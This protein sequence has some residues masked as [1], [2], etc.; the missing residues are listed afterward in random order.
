MAAGL[1]LRLLVGLA[2]VA[3]LVIQPTAPEAKPISSL[4][5]A[6]FTAISAGPDG[7]IVW[8][9]RIP[10]PAMPRL[11][12]ESIVYLP[13]RVSA[14]VRYPVVYLLQGFYGGPLQFVSG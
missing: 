10:D 12:R 11:R 9:G 1:R 8:K 4:L 13:P 6:S 14:T 5:P 2:A 7:G 3:A